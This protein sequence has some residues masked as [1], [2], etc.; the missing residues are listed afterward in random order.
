MVSLC[1]DM[2]GS[3]ERAA[4]CCFAQVLQRQ[5]DQWGMP[6]TA[7]LVIDQ[8]SSALRAASLDLTAALE[9][10]SEFLA[11]PERICES[12]DSWWAGFSSMY[13]GLEAHVRCP[14][15]LEIGT[16]KLLSQ[17]GM[18]QWSIARCGLMR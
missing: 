2:F 4:N 7:P 15:A 3:C 10:V 11:S 17:R 13:L 14:I 18:T 6:I 16:D 1:A 8:V 5:C 9:S 12:E